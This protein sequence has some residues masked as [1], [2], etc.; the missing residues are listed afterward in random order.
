[1][2]NTFNITVA[3]VYALTSDYDNE[4]IKDFCTKLQGINDR[5]N[6]DILIIQGD[7]NAKVGG[8]KLVNWKEVMGLSCNDASNDRGW[9]LMEF[10]IYNSMVL[11]N[12][13]R[14]HKAS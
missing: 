13:F 11:V 6:K 4:P 9:F 2:T 14:L 12:T 10:T 3:Q 7:W 1:M 5:L 8:D